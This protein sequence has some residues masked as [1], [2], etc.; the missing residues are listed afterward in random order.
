M[1]LLGCRLLRILCRKARRKQKR[2]RNLGKFPG[3]HQLKGFP[4][5]KRE[6]NFFVYNGRGGEL[7]ICTRKSI[8]EEELS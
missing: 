3:I 5:L 7:S 8:E 6:M 1:K 2:R 4:P